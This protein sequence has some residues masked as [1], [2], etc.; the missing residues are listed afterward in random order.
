MGQWIGI[1]III[2][3][4]LLIGGTRGHSKQGDFKTR[5]TVTTSQNN[6]G[7]SPGGG[8]GANAP[9]P[10]YGTR[11]PNVAPSGE[12]APQP[13]GGFGLGPP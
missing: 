3:G 7:R 4:S 5:P 2:A 12:Q 11:N 6:G 13:P 1:V 8:G 10:G 9:A